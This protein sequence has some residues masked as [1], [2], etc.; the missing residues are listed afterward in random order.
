[1][2]LATLLFNLLATGASL[3]LGFYI[4]T[5]SP[6]SQISWLAA[7]ALWALS[8]LLLYKVLIVEMPDPAVLFWLRPVAIFGM[9]LWFHMTH[10]LAPP[11]QGHLVALQHKVLVPLFYVATGL[12]VAGEAFSPPS[13][14]G[15]QTGPAYLLL[16]LFVLIAGSLSA[17]N[18]WRGYRRTPDPL[19][20]HI[21]MWLLVPTFVAYVGGVALGLSIWLHERV[22]YFPESLSFLFNIICGTSVLLVGYAVAKYNAF[23]EGRAIA[24]DTRYAL[25]GIGAIGV[26]YGLVVLILYQQ[27]QITFPALVFIFL[28]AIVS[29]SLYEG[30]RAALD[31]LFYHG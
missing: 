13:A 14:S 27:G 10:L 18:L 2:E 21:F 6:Q 31:R 30:S 4:V 7:V 24:Q 1:M 12:L 5:R 25:L 17:V 16:L 3:W 26:L 11:A 23:I 8:Q 19:L 29:H 15:R 20:R 9:P 22:E 28:C